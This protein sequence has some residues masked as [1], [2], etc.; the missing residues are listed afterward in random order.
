MADWEYLGNIP[1]EHGND[2]GVGALAALSATQAREALLL[3]GGTDSGVVSSFDL[4]TMT[5]TVGPDL[6]QLLEPNTPAA[7]V[8]DIEALIIDPRA[9]S[10]SPG[11]MTVEWDA[12]EGRGYAWY[13]GKPAALLPGAEIGSSSLGRVTEAPSTVAIASGQWLYVWNWISNSAVYSYDTHNHSMP[14]GAPV[15]ATKMHI[16]GDRMASWNYPSWFV[17]SQQEPPGEPA[18]I[19]FTAMERGDAFYEMPA[20]PVVGP[21]TS[22]NEHIYVLD[23]PNHLIYVFDFNEQEWS[24]W[25]ELPRTSDDPLGYTPLFTATGDRLII[26]VASDSARALFSHPATLTGPASG[27]IDIPAILNVSMGVEEVEALTNAYVTVTM[28][29]DGPKVDTT[30][31]LVAFHTGRVDTVEVAVFLGVDAPLSVQ[32]RPT[33]PLDPEAIIPPGETLPERRRVEHCEADTYSLSWRTG[34]QL[35]GSASTLASRGV[36]T[37]DHAYAVESSLPGLEWEAGGHTLATVDYQPDTVNRV[38]NEL[39]PELMPVDDIRAISVLPDDTDCP[40]DDDATLCDEDRLSGMCEARDALRNLILPTR[41]ELARAALEEVGVSLVILGGMV[42]IPG[43]ERRVNEEYRTQGKT[44]MDVV[45][46][47]LMPAGP[48]HWFAPDMLFIYGGAL[49][50]GMLAI[51]PGCT[52]GSISTRANFPRIPPEP[53]LSDYLKECGELDDCN[54]FE[55]NRDAVLQEEVWRHD[56]EQGYT[57]TTSTITKHRGQV[58]RKEELVEKARVWAY[59]WPRSSDPSWAEEHAMDIRPISHSLTTYEYLPCCPEAVSQSE[60]VTRALFAILGSRVGRGDGPGGG[61]INLGADRVVAREQARNDWHA[62]GWL[63]SRTTVSYRETGIT[64]EG[65]LITEDTEF[66]E[67]WRPVGN[68]MW[69]YSWTRITTGLMPVYEQT[70][71]GGGS[72]FPSAAGPDAP[73]SDYALRLRPSGLTLRITSESGSSITDEPPPQVRCGDDTFD[74]CRPEMTCQDI[75]TERYQQDHAEWVELVAAIEATTPDVLLEMNL[76]YDGIR[77]DILPGS[78]HEGWLVTGVSYSSTGPLG[79]SPSQST[80][81]TLISAGV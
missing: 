24:V 1:E 3:I 65:E 8:S 70:E 4:R 49:P 6:G 61:T 50:T 20:P 16:S 14:A 42:A 73:I 68:G 81:V 54:S 13:A 9:D 15:H 52:G 7:A 25:G 27:L 62:E 58:V 37:L 75:M 48:E 43:A 44:P 33:V 59:A 67:R 29:V 19:H 18:S 46:E 32:P 76:S 80:S 31:A 38:Q 72:F 41:L 12:S 5:W 23:V 21:I 2:P 51:P 30:E 74:P 79:G 45:T 71:E 40:S 66:E 17:L 10:G 35:T 57:R 78:I 28:D 34:G 77:R 56:P 26:E 11:V 39:L 22:S 69:M 55:L 47:L 60:T 53:M 64:E 63:R 36:P